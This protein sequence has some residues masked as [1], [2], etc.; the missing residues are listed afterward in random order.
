MGYAGYH[1][2][3]I[4]YL[5]RLMQQE[6]WEWITIAPGQSRQFNAAMQA[7]EGMNYLG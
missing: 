7:R 3:Q 1:T 5:S 4:V 2:E 6:G